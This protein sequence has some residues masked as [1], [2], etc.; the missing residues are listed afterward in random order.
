MSGWHTKASIGQRIY[1]TIYTYDRFMIRSEERRGRKIVDSDEENVDDNNQQF[2]R[3]NG[4]PRCGIALH[5][6][7]TKKRSKK[8]DGADT[9][10]LLQGKCKVYRNKTKHVCSYF[11]ET[12]AAKN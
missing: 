6:V 7:P 4:A 5:F 12:D 10:Y 3:S 1:N 11:S 9:Q 2:V 8:R